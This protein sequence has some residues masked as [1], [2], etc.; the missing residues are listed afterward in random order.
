MS[1]HP[2][3]PP[4]EHQTYVDPEA[5]ALARRIEAQNAAREQAA[6][7]RRISPSPLGIIAVAIA[8]AGILAGM[9][10]NHVFDPPAP[11]C[12]DAGWVTV[13]PRKGEGIDSMISRTTKNA[14]KETAEVLRQVA[15]DHNGGGTLVTGPYAVMISC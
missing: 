9:F 7:R 3:I 4:S 13:T 14:D 2:Q 5:A 6:Q 1:L 11:P 10:V 12:T 15:I 8:L